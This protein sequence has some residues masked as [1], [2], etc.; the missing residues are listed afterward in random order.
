MLTWVARG[1]AFFYF[2]YRPYEGWGS[3]VALCMALGALGAALHEARWLRALPGAFAPLAMGLFL[4]MF[5]A[6]RVRRKAAAIGVLVVGGPVLGIVTAAEAWPPASLLWGNVR[7]LAWM[8]RRVPA[9][10]PD[11]IPV[12]PWLA[13]RLAELGQGLEAF[14]WGGQ[15]FRGPAV[16]VLALLYF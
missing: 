8:L 9:A 2:R 6:K 14:M 7:H 1:I 4:G 12:G 11:Y 5:V 16:V 10:G 13:E 15:G 3:V